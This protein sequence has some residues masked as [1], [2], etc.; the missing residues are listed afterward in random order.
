MADRVPAAPRTRPT[1]SPSPQSSRL[2][3]RSQRV[4][5]Q[6][7]DI[8]DGEVER[9]S[10]L[11]RK[12]KQSGVSVD[13][14]AIPGRQRGGRPK[15]NDTTGGLQAL[16][17]VEESTP[18][19]YPK[20]PQT[21]N[22]HSA[23]SNT[24][25]GKIRQPSA[26]PTKSPGGTSTFSGTT[27]RISGS[28]HDLSATRAEDMIDALPDL[29]H[30]S[31]KILDLVMPEELS[32]SSVQIIKDQHS[33]LK[34]KQTRHLRRFVPN[35]QAQ[36][37]VY[38]GD[39]F[40]DV[41]ATV[42]A[43][44]G[45]SKVNDVRPGPWRVDP[46][47]YHA[48]LASLI[49][50]LVAQNGEDDEQLMNRLDEA[51][52]QAFV[53]FFVDDVTVDKVADGSALLRQS[54]ELALEIRS[55]FFIDSARRLLNDSGLDPDELLGQVFYTERD[56]L[57]GWNVAGLRSDDINRNEGF[58]MSIINRLDQLR[59]AFSEE[60][61]PVDLDHLD[62]AVPY[63][64]L[65]TVLLQWSRLRLREIGLQMQGFNGVAGI[66]RAV[67]TTMRGE[68]SPLDTM[69][70]NVSRGK[71]VVLEHLRLE[72]PA[73]LVFRLSSSEARQQALAR[74]KDRQGGR[75]V[76]TALAFLSVESGKKPAWTAPTAAIPA[77]TPLRTQTRIANP[78]GTSPSYQPPPNMDDENELF[79]PRGVDESMAKQVLRTYRDLEAESNK[80]NLPTRSLPF[81]P[82]K[83]N[84]SL[85]GDG[86]NKRPRA[87]MSESVPHA[88][89]DKSPQKSTAPVD[90]R[91][92]ADNSD[93][94]EGFQEDSRQM[95]SPQRPSLSS[96]QNRGEITV[97]GSAAKRRR[98]AQG[99]GHVT[100][101]IDL[102][103]V[104]EQH[105][106][107]NGPR[108]S[109]VETW[110]KVNNFAKLKTARLRKDVQVRTSWSQE[111]TDR[112]LELITDHGTSWSYL[113]VMDDNHPEGKLLHE[114]DQVALKDKARNMKADYLKSDVPLPLNF[115]AIPLSKALVQ[116]L[117][118][119][120]IRLPVAQASSSVMASL[121]DVIAELGYTV[122]QP[123]RGYPSALSQDM[124]LFSRS[125]SGIQE[126]DEL[127]DL[128]TRL[129]NQAFDNL[130]SGTSDTIRSPK[131]SAEKASPVVAADSDCV[132][133]DG[134]G[135]DEAK[136]AAEP[137]NQRSD[138]MM[139]VDSPSWMPESGCSLPKPLVVQSKIELVAAVQ[140]W[141]D[142][143]PSRLFPEIVKYARHSMEEQFA[144][145][146]TLTE[147]GEQIWIIRLGIM[148]QYMGL[149]LERSDG[150]CMLVKASFF[151]KPRG[152]VYF[153]W[154]GGDL[155][156]SDKEVA[157]HREVPKH[158]ISIRAY[159]RK[160]GMDAED[161]LNEYDISKHDLEDTQAHS[162]SQTAPARG[163]DVA[164]DSDSSVTS[165]SSLVPLIHGY[166]P[167]MDGRKGSPVK[168]STTKRRL[169]NRAPP[170]QSKA[171]KLEWSQDVSSRIT[172]SKAHGAIRDYFSQASRKV[173]HSKP[174]HL[175]F[176]P[177]GATA[178]IRSQFPVSDKNGGADVLQ[179]PPASTFGTP[180]SPA[181]SPA[182]VTFHYFLSDPLLG[183]IPLVYPTASLPSKER[184]LK[185]AI[186]AHDTVGP[187]SEVFAVSVSVGAGKR[188]VV[189]RRDGGG[190]AG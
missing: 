113:K 128:I 166:R 153:P 115:R 137:M 66:L 182:Q 145:E 60:I 2:P 80:E 73:D 175:A 116:R 29:F 24:G 98:E 143:H 174:S 45:V 141:M 4:R 65:S 179:T 5:S 17:E 49:T 53:R 163:A 63:I 81:Q 151:R 118:A 100:G 142:E 157:H 64:R 135:A 140:Q 146:A 87:E 169:S 133:V 30:A 122:D 48:N 74:F 8:S 44:L 190:K 57:K 126:I 28:G 154:L 164:E 103:D 50:A 144:T 32:E 52:P 22:D 177:L 36:R 70:N 75:R 147:T 43:V 152:H 7:R 184:F 178:S 89:S 97:P 31:N 37:E 42:R 86:R 46:V 119:V 14:S 15:Q 92:P 134:K 91:A 41:P 88:R 58:R 10:K 123:R 180:F 56:M 162:A 132:P 6:S 102:D 18:L 138:T 120:G 77:S 78:S 112:L 55:R 159:A 173:R 181:V 59:E 76:S 129:I 176:L 85:Q 111:E 21:D 124:R 105:N 20:L 35:F 54:F 69:G 136:S 127:S 39:R 109:Q 125:W 121:H 183:A 99:N 130:R 165:L 34:S 150:S 106:D 13:R 23:Q 19:K 161:V 51:F 33:D 187:K 155:G 149:L 26:Q 9:K 1:I 168:T 172:A 83:K 72:N 40:I 185:E 47:L 117:N 160:R 101:F 114:R 93:S 170:P 94:D 11:Q 38:G 25:P 82:Q 188:S 90:G 158:R 107:T 79:I 156:F 61:R 27:A 96:R 95:A 62:Q 110:Q 148:D 84:S 167:P 108:P 171:I 139:K 71:E 131:P 186:A 189:V 12:A 16:R 68:P 67:Q 104:V 3:R